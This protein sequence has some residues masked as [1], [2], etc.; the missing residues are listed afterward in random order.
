MKKAKIM[1]CTMVIFLI[2]SFALSFK[3]RNFNAIGYFYCNTAA[4]PQ[5]CMATATVGLQ[6]SLTTI[7]SPGL[8]V[9]TTLGSS[10]TLS[11]VD[12]TVQGC[13]TTLYYDPN[14]H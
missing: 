10:T 13:S 8:F 4:V 2:I 11:G 1:L 12:C 14:G 9:L 7:P 6:G 3:A 5:T